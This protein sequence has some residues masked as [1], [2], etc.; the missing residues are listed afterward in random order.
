MAKQLGI[1]PVAVDPMDL[2]AEEFALIADGR[3]VEAIK[4][5]RERTGSSLLQSKQA[6]DRARFS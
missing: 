4:H 1:D 2:D 6:A 5:H 3:V